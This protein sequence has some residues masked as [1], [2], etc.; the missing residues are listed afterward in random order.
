[1]QMYEFIFL[2]NKL[3]LNN[4]TNRNITPLSSFLC[5]W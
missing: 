5:A 4:F 1:L 2:I 3:I